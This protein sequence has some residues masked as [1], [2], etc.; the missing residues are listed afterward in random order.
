MR[1]T[2]Y[3]HYG[4]IWVEVHFAMLALPLKAARCLATSLEPKFSD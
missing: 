4:P 1:E 3:F 2:N